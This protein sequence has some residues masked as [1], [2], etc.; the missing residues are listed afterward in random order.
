MNSGLLHLAYV[1]H[2]IGHKKK[3]KVPS[4]LSLKELHWYMRQLC[5]KGIWESATILMPTL[6]INEGNQRNFLTC[7]AW[8]LTGHFGV[9]H[10]KATSKKGATH[11]KA[12]L[13]DRLSESEIKFN[14]NS[15]WT[16]RR[17]RSVL[18]PRRP[19]CNNWA[20]P[21]TS[22]AHTNSFRGSRYYAR[23]AR[24]L[25]ANQDASALVTPRR[26]KVTSAHTAARH[27]WTRTP[28]WRTVCAK[29]ETYVTMW[30]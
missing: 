30:K 16:C 5:G 14:A 2:F 24:A 17:K 3:R 21:A 9:I 29:C 28:I 23:Y 6:T 25:L 26:P 4:L 8:S 22:H 13:H 7:P 27:V 12:I 10:F 19:G 18:L 15:T 20:L 1:R 11:L